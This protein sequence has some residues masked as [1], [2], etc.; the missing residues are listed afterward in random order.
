MGGRA[1]A[2]AICAASSALPVGCQGSA[3]FISIDATQEIRDLPGN[4]PL[5][6]SSD[7][8]VGP[9][10]V[11]I[12]DDWADLLDGTIDNTLLSANAISDT[13]FQFHSGSNSDGSVTSN[14][15]NGY[16]TFSASMMSSI[17]LGNR[18]DW[19][20]MGSSTMS[21]ASGRLLCLCY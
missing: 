21:C 2:D 15:C 10:G 13:Y 5:L 3:A 20:W 4:N 8:I 14:N 7:R 1:G 12:A 9:N 16:T 18:T 6:D 11:Q 17:G 19:T